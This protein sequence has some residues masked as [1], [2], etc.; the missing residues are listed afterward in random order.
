MNRKAT[1]MAL[2]LLIIAILLI[3]G[4]AFFVRV[5]H[6]QKSLQ[7]NL[8]NTHAF[9]LAEAGF[10]RAVQAFRDPDSATTGSITNIA[11]TNLGTGEYK[12]SVVNITYV[13]STAN[14]T[15]YVAFGYV[16]NATASRATRSI[17]LIIPMF[18]NGN[19]SLIA[20]DNITVSGTS[21]NISGDVL[22]GGNL[23]GTLNIAA[24][25]T[26]VVQDQ[27]FD[28]ELLNFTYLKA[29]SQSQGNYYNTTHTFDPD[30]DSPTTF[31]YNN[32]T[33]PNVVY[34]EGLNL[35]L[36]GNDQI[37]G[38][39]IVGGDATYDAS[40]VGTSQVDGCIYTQGDFYDKGGGS[41]LDVI[42]TIWA[43]GN[44]TL[45]G[46]VDLVFNATYYQAMRVLIGR[47]MNITWRDIETPYRL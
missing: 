41:N 22:Y 46:S 9:W 13:N 45:N 18:P 37:H 29:L 25:G 6:D 8:E 47:S 27:N 24:P 28:F 15:A 32:T 21:N 20:D 33:T 7:R 17:E 38:F 4:T 3:F 34:L 40:I 23:T 35:N 2:G 5:V 16:P 1:I 30:D 39:F 11:L 12:F 31:F 36:K 44:A 19:Y 10:N 26:Q 42:G 14:R 43:G